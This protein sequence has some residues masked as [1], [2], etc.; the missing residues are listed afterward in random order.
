MPIGEV[1]QIILRGP[2][3]MKEYYKNPKATAETLRDGWL[4][5]GDMGYCDSEGYLYYTDRS[6]DMIVRGGNNV[7]SVEVESVIYEHPAVKQCAVIAKPLPQLGEDI[8]AF[9]VLK[10]G[11]TLTAEELYEFTVDKLADYRRPRDVRFV[12]SLP[13]NP[14]GKMDKKRIRAEYLEA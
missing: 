12:E 1:G 6:K 2:N 13:L 5:T 11:E 4:Y 10:D 14:T 7:Y 3:V 8:L 9:I